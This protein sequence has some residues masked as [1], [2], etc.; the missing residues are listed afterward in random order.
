MIK[1]LKLAFPRCSIKKY[2]DDIK[3][4]E[5]VLSRDTSIM[6]PELDTS[7]NPCT[8]Q[9]NMVLNPKKCKEMIVRCRRHVEQ[10]PP[11][12]TIDNKTLETV[13]H[14]KVLGVTLQNNLKWDLHVN[15]IVDKLSERL[16]ILRVLIKTWRSTSL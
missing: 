5:V 10:S 4:W 1:D 15:E 9:N 3:V 6:Q 16:H 7:I 14:D 2:V 8:T 11:A 12:L 13:D